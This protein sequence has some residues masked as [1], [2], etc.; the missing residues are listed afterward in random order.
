MSNFLRNHQTDFQ[1]GFTSLQSHQQ[2]RNVPL[3]PHPRQHLLSPEFFILVVLTG[4]RWNLR[5]VLICISL[6]TKDIKHF[7]R[8]QPFHVPQ[9]RIFVELCTPFLIGSFGY[10]KDKQAEK[11]IREIKPFTVVKNNI[12]YLILTLTKHV[13]DLYDQDLNSLKKD[14]ED[15]RRWEDLP[16]LWIGRITIVKMTI[17]MKAI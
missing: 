3:S 15:L 7:F 2:W 14:S 9:L 6:M 17:L 4:M 10:S 16:C 12:K 8:F 1:G 13:K 11:E 5:A